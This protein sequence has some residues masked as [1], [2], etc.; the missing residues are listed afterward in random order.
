[1]TQS[2]LNVQGNIP[3]PEKWTPTPAEIKNLVTAYYQKKRYYDKSRLESLTIR[4]VSP[5]PIYECVLETFVEE[6]TY[7]DCLEPYDGSSIEAK[8]LPPLWHT[9]VEPPKPFE[10]KQLSIRMPGTEKVRTCPTCKGN[11]R[12]V[13]EGCKGAGRLRCSACGGRG[14]NCTC[15][16]GYRN[17]QVCNGLREL[18]CPACGGY[19]QQASYKALKVRFRVIEEHRANRQ[20]DSK[21]DA[22]LVL[23]AWQRSL[24][25]D[26]LTNLPQE[27]KVLAESLLRTQPNLLST[28]EEGSHSVLHRQ[29]LKVRLYKRVSADYQFGERT[30][31][32]ILIGTEQSLES[33]PFRYDYRKIALHFGLG[34]AAILLVTGG[35]A[36]FQWIA[37]ENSYQTAVGLLERGQPGEA[38]ALFHEL[39]EKNF[40]DSAFRAREASLALASVRLDEGKHAEAVELLKPLTAEG[41]P[42]SQELLTRAMYE[43]ETLKGEGALKKKDYAAAIRHFEQAKAISSNPQADELLETARREQRT[44]AQEEYQQGLRFMSRGS[45]AQAV[46]AFDTALRIYPEY[47]AAAQKRNEAKKRQEQIKTVAPTSPPWLESEA[48]IASDVT[49]AQVQALRELVRAW[50]FRCD[51]VSGAYAWIWNPGFTLNCNGFRYVYSIEDKGGIWTV[52]VE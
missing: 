39:S 33:V 45:Y 26:D 29:R 12:I 50:G 48:I 8:E 38:L 5:A 37:R 11:R 43:Q 2:E 23:E 1:M 13:C 31:T 36:L 41:W 44:A 27:G 18:E 21:P 40:K 35:V 10:E 16:G 9:K 46:T 14:K 30:G 51:S 20:A 22:E 32:I 34:H 25:L 28:P 15:D 42:K 52:R 17:C 4:R 7:D 19:G 49:L 24:S 47:A 3:P 6:R